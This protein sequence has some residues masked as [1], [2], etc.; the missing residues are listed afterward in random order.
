MK[1]KGIQSPTLGLDTVKG[2][3][4][5][6]YR[7]L[8]LNT[9]SELEL[10]IEKKAITAETITNHFQKFTSDAIQGF[11]E[12]LKKMLISSLILENDQESRDSL[13]WVYS[14]IDDMLR[15]VETSKA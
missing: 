7:N 14:E 9:M 10:T 5:F 15:I 1:P 12:D 3:A 2:N 11:R 8:I 13:S 6:H 4:V